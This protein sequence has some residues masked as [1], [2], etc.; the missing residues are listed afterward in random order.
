VYNVCV[1]QKW[2]IAEF[3][4][5]FFSPG[6][7]PL[8]QPPEAAILTSATSIGYQILAGYVSFHMKYCLLVWNENGEGLDYVFQNGRIS[9]ARVCLCPLCSCYHDYEIANSESTGPI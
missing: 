9:E 2:Q 8:W 1:A 5:E 6:P 4:I 7:W 3:L